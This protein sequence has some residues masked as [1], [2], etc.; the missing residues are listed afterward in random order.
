MLCS[1]WWNASDRIRRRHRGGVVA[2]RPLANPGVCEVKRLYVPSAFQGYRI[3]DQLVVALITEART[4]GYHRMRL[5]SLRRYAGRFFDFAEQGARRNG[6]FDRCRTSVPRQRKLPASTAQR[7]CGPRTP[8]LLGYHRKRVLLPTSVLKRRRNDLGAELRRPSDAPQHFSSVRR[9]A[10]G[11]R[12][13]AGFQ[14]QLRHVDDAHQVASSSAR[15]VEDVEP[16][17]RH[18]CCA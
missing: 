6:C 18:R 9:S 15:Q 16:T 7:T 12:Y 1:A 14:L 17:H 8:D 13:I 5:D 10:V 3:G 2:L 4:R 11:C